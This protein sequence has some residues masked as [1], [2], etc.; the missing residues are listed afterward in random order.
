MTDLVE[1]VEK[2]VEDLFDANTDKFDLYHTLRVK[3]IAESLALEEKDVEV[4]VVSLASLLHDIADERHYS[5]EK[6]GIRQVSAILREAGAK[7]SL[8]AHVVDIVSN[9]FFKGAG[10]QTPMKT[11]EGK[12]VQDAER[13]DS[14]GAI[15]IV[16]CFMEGLSTGR[17]MYNTDYVPQRHVSK[18]AYNNS[19][20]DSLNHFHEK[21]Y[22]LKDNMNTLAGKR[23]A[24][25][26][27]KFMKKFEQQFRL[28]WFA[29]DLEPI[30]QK[31]RAKSPWQDPYF[32]HYFSL[33]VAAIK[34]PVKFEKMNM[35]EYDISAP[36]KE[37]D[38]NK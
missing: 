25:K 29:N 15:G 8:I 38:K 24:A 5:D 37:K 16:R 18:E 26:R 28:E 20:T 4:E 14:M 22:Y 7:P 31:I 9:M 34:D 6:E 35:D 23:L 10:V 13:L 32:L 3:A 12:I 30:L 21:L 1:K 27:H 17:E 2:I 36:E 33:M 19:K 11:I